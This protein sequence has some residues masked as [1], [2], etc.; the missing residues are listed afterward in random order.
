M[1]DLWSCSCAV[2]SRDRDTE[3]DSGEEHQDDLVLEIILH[4]SDGFLNTWTRPHLELKNCCFYTKIIQTLT[5]S[6]K[7]PFQILVTSSLNEICINY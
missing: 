3:R 6:S 5:N 1:G 2:S 7:N 4:V